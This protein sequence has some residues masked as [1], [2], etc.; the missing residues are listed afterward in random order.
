ME[1]GSRLLLALA[2]LSVAAPAQ[3]AW[4][5]TGYDAA[6]TSAP[7]DE[8]PLA[9][10]VAW[11][12]QLPG[13]RV[14][15]YG[16]AILVMGGS[17]YVLT[18]AYP[19]LGEGLTTNGLFRVDVHTAQVTLLVE[20]D[21]PPNVIASDGQA[22]YVAR[23]NGLGAYALDGS[24]LWERDL[25][26]GF[27]SRVFASCSDMALRNSTLYLA[28]TEVDG[29]PTGAAQPVLFDYDGSLVSTAVVATVD[30]RT[31]A[32]G[33]VWSEDP[34]NSTQGGPNADAP[35]STQPHTDSEANWL[36]VVGPYVFATNFERAGYFLGPGFEP[37][38]PLE[39]AFADLFVAGA[40]LWALN[41]EDGS[42]R[43]V[44]NVTSGKRVAAG[45][46]G[47]PAEEVVTDEPP[48]PSGALTGTTTAVYVTL[49]RFEALN[50]A[51][52][53]VLWTADVG[54][55]DA[56]RFEN[57]NAIALRDTALYVASTQTV[58]RFDTE[59]KQSL[60]RYTLPANEGWGTAFVVTGRALYGRA[61]ADADGY[62]AIYAFDPAVRPE[63]QR[64]LWRHAFQSATPT[65]GQLFRYAVGDGVLAVAGQDGALA[66]LGRTAASLRPAAQASTAF[67]PAG[68][69]VRVDLSGTAPG[70]LGPATRFRADWGDG[71]ASDWQA[72]P[73]LTHA[74]AAAGEREARV[75]A[76][77]DANQTSSEVVVFHVGSAPPVALSPLQQAFAPENQNLTL[78]FVG[79]AL[80]A[81]AAVPGVARLRRKRSRLREELKALER[82]YAM[83]RERP[84]DCEAALAERKAR[85]RGMLLDGKLDE[86]QFAI[87]EKRIDELRGTLRLGALEGPLRFLPYSMVLAL[88]EVLADGRVTA[89]EREQFLAALE[90]DEHL[91][92]EQKQKVRAQLDAWFAHDAGAAAAR[93]RE[94]PS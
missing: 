46:A 62:N 57:A 64:V 10:E 13:G 32:T 58:H 75:W 7:A 44:H 63:G 31:G 21:A 37:G 15:G 41:E 6:R 3:A 53:D 33:W 55:E 94:G 8:G 52:G 92:P 74:Y 2:A 1:A 56:T 73:V 27:A 54:A 67:P 83:T 24:V 11:T 18:G 61:Y 69:E 22:L 45:Y 80:T 43:W 91:H 30:A 36:S 5:Q 59:T 28:C 20:F 4:L 39:P 82:A 70:L 60:W 87:L 68:Q 89:W 23:D 16:T 88:R 9:D 34:A 29:V 93:Q 14:G 84:G 77:N 90:R 25:P 26:Q 72:S 49:D 81:M 12:V 40:S 79:L 86:A 76:G 17:V 38:T 47:T 42:V 71:S 66:L 48:G 35:T 65:G 19:G 51:L 50:P 78:F 85:A